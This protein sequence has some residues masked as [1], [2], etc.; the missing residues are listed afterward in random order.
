[1]ETSLAY[2]ATLNRRAPIP[3]GY[4]VPPLDATSITRRGPH[5]SES[6]SLLRAQLREQA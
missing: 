1:M 4:F 3:K 5:S 2:F 6:E